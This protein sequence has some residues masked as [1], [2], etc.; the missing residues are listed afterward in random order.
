[1]Q[2]GT[3]ILQNL[4][5]SDKG[6]HICV[7]AKPRPSRNIANAWLPYTNMGKFRSTFQGVNQN[8]T[9]KK[10]PASDMNNLS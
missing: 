10:F 2:A 9:F 6:R 1:M 3:P 5:K 8:F 4:N 7:R